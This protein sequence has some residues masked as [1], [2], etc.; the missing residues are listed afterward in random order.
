MKDTNVVCWDDRDNLERRIKEHELLFGNA[1][2]VND[3]YFQVGRFYYRLAHATELEKLFTELARVDVALGSVQTHTAGAPTLP[4]AERSSHDGKADAGKP[5]FDLLDDGC[6]NALLGVVQVLTWAVETKGYTAGSWQAVLDAIRRY[7][8]A[9]RRHQNAKARG[10]RYDAESGLLHDFHIAA[11]AMFIAELEA[12]A[13][14]AKN[15]TC[16]TP[17]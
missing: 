7:S 14:T 8:A 5:R 4:I 16:K 9:M 15:A 12:R 10:E 2:M 11:C 6:P 1:Y 3:D 17:A 13:D